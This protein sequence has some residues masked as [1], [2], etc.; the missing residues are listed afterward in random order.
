MKGDFS[1][2]RFERNKHY[3][4]VLEQQGRVD[5]DADANEQR[6][7]D[8]TL[9]ETINTDVIGGY[10]APECAPGFEI[11]LEGDKI[12]I[13]PGRYYVHG[14]LCENKD[15]LD[16]DSQPYL[17]EPTQTASQLLEQLLE[18]QLGS[19]LGLVLEVWQRL[20]TALDDPCLLEPALGQAD[21][22]ARLQTV[23]RVTA[24][25]EEKSTAK[26]GL[27]PGDPIAKLAPCCQVLY[28]GKSPLHNG[29]MAAS[30]APAGSDCGCQPIA[31]AGYQGLE[32]QLY[33]VEIHIGG[34]LNTATFKWSRENGA[35]VAAVTAVA[36]G[37]PV[38][39]LST[40]RPDPN[41]G[42][43]AGQWIEL[44]DD[45]YQ[46]GDEPN[47]HGLLFHVQSA[48]PATMQVTMMTPVF[49]IDTTK[50][51]RMRRWDQNG[52]TATSDGIPVSNTPI[53]LENGIQ[54]EFKAGEFQS[55][56]YWTIPA[57]TAIG[58]IEWPPCG[59]DGDY[60]Q[61][62]GYME[63][64]RAPLACVAVPRFIPLERVTTRELRSQFL[65]NDC[66]LLFP[67]L[68]AVH[69]EAAA[70][71][72]HV[73]AI[74]W[75]NDDVMTTDTFLETGLSVTFDQ[76]T[77]CPWGGGN[78]QVTIEPP[79]GV[80]A[81]FTLEEGK[82]PG[83]PKPTF[84]GAPGTDS[85]VR[86]V[87][88]LDP[89]F[90]IT[91]TGNRV[92]WLQPASPSTNLAAT[93]NNAPLQ[94]FPILNNLLFWQK[95]VGYGRVRVRFIGGAV[96]GSG[97]S[98]N[99]YLDGQ[100]LGQTCNRAMDQSP[101]VA[102]NLPSGVSAAV[103]DYEGWFYL[104]PTVVI[105]NV[106]I[107]GTVNGNIATVSAIIVNSNVNGTITGLQVGETQ[108]VTNL[109]ASVT[110][111]YPPVAPITISLVFSGTGA[112]TI[113]TIAASVPVAAG[114]TSFT[115][116]INVI[117]N[118][119]AGVK[120]T[121]TLIASV[122]SAIGAIPATQQP[123]LT[124]GGTPPQQIIQ[125]TDMRAVWSFWSKPFWTHKRH[126]WCEP[127][128]HLLAWGLSL[129]LARRHFAKTQLVTDTPGKA[130]LIDR[131][132]LE[133]DDVRIDL[134]GLHDADP[135]WW[136]LGKLTAY[137]LQQEPFVHLDTD[138]F[139]WKAL[140]PSLIAAPV[141][142]QCPEVHSRNDRWGGPSQV[143]ALFEHHQLSLPVEWE[144]AS[145][146]DTY[147]FREENC[148]II[149]GNRVDF[150]RHYA[151]TAIRLIQDPAHRAAWAEVTDKGS[152]TL[153][154]MLEQ[155]LLASCLEYHRIDP[156]SPYRGVT[157]RHL[158]PSWSEACNP[159]ASARVGYTHLLGEKSHPAVMARLEQRV[160]QI[161]PAFARH[162]ER[163]AA[164]I[165]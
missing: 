103:S 87:V 152:G 153:N 40:L 110:L 99:I 34:D 58:Q 89:P 155:Y 7:I 123:T 143:E 92:F 160:A 151:Q 38:I 14:I 139:L 78:F 105:T 122:P 120:D 30:V 28:E 31:A 100:S 146:V 147:T 24:S 131:L 20:V 36:A 96:Y 54:V 101:A 102:Y 17:I 15:W 45:T 72:L 128:H 164:A 9:R 144:W 94:L 77:T 29:R 13:G 46:F 130:M 154:M 127:R 18:A 74:S 104:A 82:V 86:T 47:Q 55:G 107:Q 90:G 56:D 115:T 39:T 159:H 137:S 44:I 16:Y 10:G 140:P 37:S 53:P 141:L 142:T 112:G 150:L 163:V 81:A 148:G 93:V 41:L 67:P 49:G 62:A 111:S 42:F 70:A 43:Q 57:R 32:N 65:V 51:A 83:I 117:A 76:P 4:A 60:F 3:T 61:P 85:F 138:V 118:P 165:R 84:A 27:K 71:A 158:F 8:R 22:T 149:G 95:F 80:G 21:T 98:G 135:G 35:V 133:F 134:D 25:I 156:H 125:Q 145:S 68:V 116:P 2:I 50:N 19:T 91:V 109:Q 1:R 97:T 11:K 106:V 119:G 88:E 63:I 64:Y 5:L 75:T 33:R 157:V 114:Q 59:V 132:G 121:V 113:V 108:V 23:W 26:I 73:A 124:I 69:S 162:C 129:K 126:T 66:R 52:A 12:L 136:A 48:N 6:A 161:D 79:F